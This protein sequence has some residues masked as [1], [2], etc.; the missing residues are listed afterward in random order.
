MI[1]LKSIILENGLWNWYKQQLPNW[2]DYVIKDF[3][4]VK[5]KSVDD[6]NS[7]K[8]WID[9]LKKTYPTIKWKLEKLNLTFDSFDKDTKEIMKQRD[10]GKSNP[11][12]VPKDT[13]RH[14]TQASLLQ[15][16]GISKEPIIVIK[17]P[18]GYDLWEGWHRTL[19]YLKQFPEGF[20]C[21][22]WVG[23]P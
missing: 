3:I 16:R 22:S 12:Q 9:D 18:D 13:E 15:R 19:Q 7:K 4:F 17:T 11:H 21:P 23:Y 1:K 10:M 6:M 20:I 14:Q 2:P 8:E 5:L